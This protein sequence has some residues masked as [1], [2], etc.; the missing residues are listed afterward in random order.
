VLARYDVVLAQAQKQLTQA[1]RIDEALLLKKQRED[2][3]AR[4][5]LAAPAIAP[6]VAETSKPACSTSPVSAS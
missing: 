3:A 6:A 1:Q 2:V 4:W 5:P